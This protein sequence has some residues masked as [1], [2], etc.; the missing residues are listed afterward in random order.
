MD[1]PQVPFE[2]LQL[3]LFFGGPRAPL[4]TPSVLRQL[5]R[6]SARSRRGRAVAGESVLQSGEFAVTSGPAA[7]RARTRSRSRRALQRWLECLQAG[8]FTNFTLALSRPDG[9]QAITGLDG[10]LPAGNAAMLAS[11]TPC[12]EPQASL[13][14]CGPESE[15]GQATAS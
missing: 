6:R 8:A 7:V 13:G 2:E 3:E 4:A 10:R 15:I 12:P 9:D 11:V 14:E 5:S 1:T